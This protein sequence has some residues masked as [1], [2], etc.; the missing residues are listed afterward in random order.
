MEKIKK[1][2]AAI[3]I[4]D[5]NGN[6][7]GCHATGKP[8]YTGYDFPKGCVEPGESDI[9]TAI[10]E[11]KE[12][13]GLFVSE[14]DLIDAGV[15]P[16]NKEK[17]IHLFIYRVNVLPNTT[18]LKCTSYFELPDGRKLPEMNGFKIIS[19][20]ERDMFNKVLQNKFE[21]IDSFNK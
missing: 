19:K 10:R 3:V 5:K 16:H 18:T 15:H 21:I 7:L 11:L 17:D 2:T 6:I 12:E 14:S 13:T 9:T 8:D 4:I 20:S 1:V